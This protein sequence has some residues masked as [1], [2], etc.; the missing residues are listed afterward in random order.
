VHHYPVGLLELVEKLGV[1]NVCL[2]T[3]IVINL[4]LHWMNGRSC[5][6]E[7]SGICESRRRKKI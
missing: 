2:E 1:P 3:S 7:R 5:E 6:Y 4:H